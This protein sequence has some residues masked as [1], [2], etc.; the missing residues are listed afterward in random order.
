MTEA[1]AKYS[2]GSRRQVVLHVWLALERSSH[3][4]TVRIGVTFLASWVPLVLLLAKRNHRDVPGEGCIPFSVSIVK[5][6]ANSVGM[7]V[8]LVD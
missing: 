6:D 2:E 5:Y 1:A 4:R 7:I 3:R 8:V